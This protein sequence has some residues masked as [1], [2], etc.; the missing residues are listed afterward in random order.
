MVAA[1][2]HTRRGHH[3]I[4][5]VVFAGLVPGL[6]AANPVPVAALHGGRDPSARLDRLSALAHERGWPLAIAPTGTH[7]LPIERPAMVARWVREAVIAPP[8]PPHARP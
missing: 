8:C 1:F 3:T 4:N 2:R 6:A 7:Q 5:T